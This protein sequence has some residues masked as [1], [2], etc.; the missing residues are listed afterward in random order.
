MK[1][2]F[3]C[4]SVLLIFFLI[5]IVAYQWYTS[6]SRLTYFAFREMSFTDKGF[7]DSLFPKICFV[8]NSITA[9]WKVLSPDFFSKNGYLNRGV[10]GN[11]SNQILLRFQRDIVDIQPNI[12]VL[13]C[14]INDIAESDGFYNQEFTLQNIQSIVDICKANNIVV[15]LSSVLPVGDIKIDRVT[16]LKGKQH[17]V[18]DLN[19]KVKDLA[20][21]NGI[22]YIDYHSHLKN[23]TNALD[24]KYT[25]DGV[26]PNEE[27]YKIMERIVLE[28][29]N[30]NN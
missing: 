25:F 6:Q 24:K 7:S 21:K 28:A 18:I 22:M 29:L 26:H 1:R 9:N 5:G 11:S 8:G 20:S 10:G 15:I 17:E 4:L 2:Y 23:E 30:R 27:G 12:V 13:N 14:G 19:E 16:T 3:I